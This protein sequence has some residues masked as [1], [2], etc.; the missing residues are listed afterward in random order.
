MKKNVVPKKKEHVDNN[1]GKE[2]ALTIK[3][4]Y[5]DNSYDLSMNFQ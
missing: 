4:D 1:Q 5:F 3:H 2:L